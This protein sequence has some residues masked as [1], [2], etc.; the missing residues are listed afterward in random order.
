LVRQAAQF[1]EQPIQVRGVGAV[2][3]PIFNF[4]G[5]PQRGGVEGITERLD[6]K[7]SN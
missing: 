6:F 7:P 4:F 5:N 1:T 2:G 3:F